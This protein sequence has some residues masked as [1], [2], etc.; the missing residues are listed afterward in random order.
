MVKINFKLIVIIS[1]IC[2]SAFANVALADFDSADSPQ[3]YLNL[4]TQRG[5]PSLDS[6]DSPIFSLNLLGIRRVWADSDSFYFDWFLGTSPQ[7]GAYRLPV[8]PSDDKLLEFNNGAWVIPANPPPSGAT[9]IILNH[10]WNGGP[11]DYVDFAQKIADLVPDAYIYIWHWGDGEN[12]PSQSNPNGLTTLSDF[13]P[14]LGCVLSSAKCVLGSTAFVNEIGATLSNAKINGW[15]LGEKLYKFGIRPDS[16]YN[17]KIHMIGHS[18]GGVVSANAASKLYA[19]TNIKIK[20]LTATDTPALIW[21][22]AINSVNPSSA[23]R[24]EVL[25]YD[26]TKNL[27]LGATGGPLLTTSDNVLNVELNPIYYLTNPIPLHTRA[28]DWYL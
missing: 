22:Y 2:F 28:K 1:S 23:E 7:Q 16:P 19:K 18:F 24:V 3:F 13:A 15:L 26:W 21:P 10:G 25:Y 6:S 9:V 27:L 12:T 14:L 11:L 4:L 17:H 8:Q 5:A 20:Q